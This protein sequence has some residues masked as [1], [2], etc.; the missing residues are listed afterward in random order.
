MHEYLRGVGA[1]S[2]VFGWAGLFLTDHFWYFAVG[3]IYASFVLFGL[4][5]WHEP[6]FAGKPAYRIAVSIIVLLL[7][8]FFTWGFVLAPAPLGV[9]AYATDGEYPGGT[10]IAGINWNRGFT[11]VDVVLK[12]PTDH[13]YEDMNVV[14]KPTSPV[15]AIAQATN[16]SDVSIEDKFGESVRGVVVGGGEKKAIPLV[17]IA[18][19]AGYRVRCGRLPPQT[20]LRIVLAL[21]E[22][23]WNP[24]KSDLPLDEQVLLPYFMIRNK[25]DDMSSYWWGHKDWDYFAARPTSTDW[26]K[27]EGTYIALHRQRSV[28]E[29]VSVGGEVTIRTMP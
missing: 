28:S 1:T 9:S 5:I 10:V 20:G 19:D 11:E 12:N 4:D 29:L 18:T 7:A 15:A 26:V 17:L 14:I 21:A 27:I 16:I 8:S 23:K 6:K 13:A 24:Q 22:I 2:L 3:L 25:T